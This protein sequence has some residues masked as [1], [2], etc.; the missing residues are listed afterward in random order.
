MEQKK[1]MEEIIK[2]SFIQYSGAVL[3]SRALVDVRDCIKPSTRQVLYCLYTDKFL[4]DKPFKKTM[5]A[6]GSAMRLYI[7]G[8]ASCIG[9]MMRC[10]QGFTMR[11]PLA[12]IEG[13][14]GNLIES[15]NYAAPRY[16]STRLSELSNYLMSDIQKDTIA[17]WRDNYDDTE[18][19]PSV[20]PSK[21]FYNVVNGTSGIGIGMGSSCPQF[22]IK[23]VNAALEKLLLNPNVDFDAIYC[24][25]DFATG[26]Y[27]INEKEVKETLKY[28]CKK[29]AKANDVEGAACK[30]R[31]KI[32]VDPEDETGRTL[33]VTEIPYG[34]YTNTIV[35]ELDS[36]LKSED[37]PGIKR[38]N[39]LTGEKVLIKIY[40]EEGASHRK[41]INYLYKHTSLQYHFSINLTMLDEGRFPK[42]FTWKEMLQAHINHEIEVYRRGFEFDLKE[43]EHKIHIIDGLLRCLASIDEVV[44]VIKSS[45][46]TSAARANLITSFILDREQADAVLNMKL[47]RLA[48]LEIEKLENERKELNNEVARITAVLNNKDLFNQE[49]IKG[50]REISDKFGDEHRTKIIEIKEEEKEEVPAAEKCKITV[51]INGITINKITPKTKVKKKKNPLP[52][53]ISIDTDSLDTL[54]LFTNKGKFYRTFVDDIPSSDLGTSLNSIFDFEADEIVIAATTASRAKKD[55]YVICVTKQGIFKKT[56]LEDYCGIKRG[57]SDGSPAIKFKTNTDSI[58]NITFANEEE[59]LLVTKN[60]M[61]IRFETKEISPISKNTTGVIGMKLSENDSIVCGIPLVDNKVAI[62]TKNGVGKRLSVNEIPAQNRG[63]KG[64]LFSKLKEDEIAAVLNVKDKDILFI[65]STKGSYITAEDITEYAKSSVGR[66][67]DK[68]GNVQSVIKVL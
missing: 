53:L 21:G 64:N 59:Y 28:G 7:H 34:V 67:V 25:P 6:L 41:I 8:D 23:D 2:Q 47:S 42:V 26:G 50:W 29:N 38:F 24:P 1:N 33:I 62:F 51:G 55:K 66:F 20:L 40:P 15:G 44:R 43:L 17:D 52:N 9:I 56:P 32:E 39:D 68:S 49:L 57:K 4:F 10:G 58:A 14:G 63:G 11:Y 54:I 19:Y 18:Q 12:E 65:N 3:Q 46:S 35:K 27:L 48:H 16:T 22:N 36:I 31:A 60:G 30:L 37:N 5:K 45:E 13:N 61:A